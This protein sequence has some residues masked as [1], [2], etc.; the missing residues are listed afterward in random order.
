[1]FCAWRGRCPTEELRGIDLSW[2]LVFNSVVLALPW[3]LLATRAKEALV[4]SEIRACFPG[5]LA[6]HAALDCAVQDRGSHEES[7][8]LEEGQRGTGS[9]QCG[10]EHRSAHSPLDVPCSAAMHSPRSAAWGTL[11]TQRPAAHAAPG[12]ALPH[13]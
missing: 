10:A 12:Q 2:V 11:P 3:T 4:S 9:Q 1:M 6:Q 5:A 8:A 7:T 13:P